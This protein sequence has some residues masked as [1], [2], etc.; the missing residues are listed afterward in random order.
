MMLMCRGS[1]W[2]AHFDAVLDS[3]TP[4]HS[5]HF[6][7]TQTESSDVSPQSLSVCSVLYQTCSFLCNS[8]VNYQTGRIFYKPNLIGFLYNA[9]ACATLEQPTPSII[10]LSTL[11]LHLKSLMIL[12][13][14]SV[15]LLFNISIICHSVSVVLMAVHQKRTVTFESGVFF[16]VFT[17][18]IVFGDEFGMCAE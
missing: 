13:C 10:T 17:F 5:P 1:C 12:A 14:L 7:P 4:P 9:T 6:P 8:S 11:E 3:G 18:W 16:S 2:M 15:L